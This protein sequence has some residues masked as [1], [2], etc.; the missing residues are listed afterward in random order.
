MSSNSCSISVPGYL[1]CLASLSASIFSKTTTRGTSFSLSCF[2]TRS[3]HQSPIRSYF[4]SVLQVNTYVGV[5]S[6]LYST[7]HIIRANKSDRV[8]LGTARPW[9]VTSAPLCPSVLISSSDLRRV[10]MPRLTCPLNH[11][12]TTL[13]PGT[14]ATVRMEYR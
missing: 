1:P 14:L 13:P 4:K 8:D 2:W 12:D 9:R 6:V 3:S 5:C 7:V 11:D 10:T